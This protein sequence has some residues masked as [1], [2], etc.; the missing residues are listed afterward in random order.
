MRTLLEDCYDV[1]SITRKED[2]LKL[3]TAKIMQM[4]KESVGQLNQANHQQEALQRFQDEGDV[5]LNKFKHLKQQMA[6]QRKEYKGKKQEWMDN[7]SKIK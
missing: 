5:H 6:L 4:R 1:V 2:E 7:Q 3:R